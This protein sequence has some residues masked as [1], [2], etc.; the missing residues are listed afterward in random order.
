MP[1]SNVC[2]REKVSEWIYGC[3]VRRVWQQN[4][5]SFHQQDAT[6]RSIGQG[7]QSWGGHLSVRSVRYSLVPS[8]KAGGSSDHV[9]SSFCPMSFFPGLFRV[10][11]NT[12]HV[13]NPNCKPELSMACCA[14][15]L[16]VLCC[17]VR[18]AHQ[19]GTIAD[20]LHLSVLLT[21][22]IKYGK[23]NKATDRILKKTAHENTMQTNSK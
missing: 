1:W 5:K 6:F 11:L 23:A 9:N 21:N 14:C 13:F 8:K 4:K 19:A 2:V 20:Q 16:P 7:P 15:R 18:N 22:P 10:V 3:D 12:P 17:R